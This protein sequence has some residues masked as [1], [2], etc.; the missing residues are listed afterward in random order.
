[1]VLDQDLILRIAVPVF[2]ALLGG[3][4]VHLL[5]ERRGR[6]TELRYWIETSRVA[7]PPAGL[8]SHPSSFEVRFNGRPVTDLHVSKLH[9]QNLGPSDLKDIVVT[10][11]TSHGWTIISASGKSAGNPDMLIEREPPPMSE[12]NGS[13]SGGEATKIWRRDYTIPVLNRKT[14]A[15]F[16]IVYD[17]HVSTGDLTVACNHVG[18][19]L[20]HAQPGEALATVK[21]IAI[22]SIPLLR[23]LRP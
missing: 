10:L 11:Q 17:R 13:I 3:V 21:G 14:S 15:E 5:T 6:I 2:T 18:V 9:L 16:T 7:D 23:L 12:S 1:M 4:F 22:E 8:I 19:R 20:L